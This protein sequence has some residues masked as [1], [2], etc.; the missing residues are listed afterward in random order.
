MREFRVHA[1]ATGPE[2]VDSGRLGDFD[3]VGLLSL[4]PLGP[5]HLHVDVAANAPDQ[6]SRSRNHGSRYEYVTA[7]Q[8]RRERARPDGGNPSTT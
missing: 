2:R 3:R 7:C 1:P 6:R 5:S 4:L 8:F